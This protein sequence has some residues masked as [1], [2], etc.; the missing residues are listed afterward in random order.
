MSNHEWTSQDDEF[1]EAMHRRTEELYGVRDLTLDDDGLVEAPV[2]SLRDVVVYPQ[3][4][5]PVFFG[6]NKTLWAIEEAQNKNQTVIALTQ[7]DPSVEKPGPDDFISIGVEMAVGRLLNMP[8]GSKSALVQARRR[9]EVVEFTQV[10]PYL[11]A[12]VHPI[13]ESVHVDRQTDALVRTVLEMFNRCVQLD[14]SLPE[15]AYLFAMNIDEPSWLA[16]MVATALR[17]TLLS[18]LPTL[19]YASFLT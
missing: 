3:M 4:V 18:P 6:R 12:R 2:I 8:D 5:S 15:E 13:Y 16:D 17:A 7:I 14:R 1:P 10:E 11:R 9:V 19:R